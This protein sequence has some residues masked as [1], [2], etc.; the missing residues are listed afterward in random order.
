MTTARSLTEPEKKIVASRQQWRC[1][2]CDD[3]LSSAY[4]V[5]H[6]IPLCDG[7]A[8]DIANCTAMCANC[9][10][11]KTQAEH[12][13]RRR[14]AMLQPERQDV[15]MANGTRV[16]CMSC[17]ATR[18][19]RVDHPLCTAYNHPQLQRSIIETA[20]SEFKFVPRH[21]QK[22]RQSALDAVAPLSVAAPP[23]SQ[24]SP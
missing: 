19:A 3:V 1:S 6:T 21:Q 14:L 2:Q 16:R 12:V 23:A 7:G 11:L 5:D 4:Q 10:A 8:D 20:L 17:R 9:H 22:K 13:A 24:C 15:F 18:D